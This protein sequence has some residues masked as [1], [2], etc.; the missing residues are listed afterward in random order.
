[1][2]AVGALAGLIFPRSINL[3]YY[4]GNLFLQYIISV[5]GFIANIDI[6]K[7]NLDKQTSS[8]ILGF[9]FVFVA[10]VLFLAC[11][12]KPKPLVAS[13]LAC[14]IFFTGV[15]GNAY[16]RRNET[17]IR[18]IDTGNGMCVLFMHG[19]ENILVGCGGTDFM[20]WSNISYALKNIGQLDCLIIPSSHETASSCAIGIL[21][22]NKPEDIIFDSL[23]EN[24][25]YLIGECN[26]YS[27]DETYKTKN[28]TVKFCKVNGRPYILVETENLSTL[29]YNFPISSIDELPEEFGK[30]NLAVCRLA[31]PTGISADFVAVC[32]DKDTGDFARNELVS[33]GIPSAATGGCGDLI[34]RAENGDLNIRRE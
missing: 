32:A 8:L 27:F 30:V 25:E 15:L 31:Y 29:I 4:L 26:V 7:V 5:S 33:R 24:A 28:F 34:I 18:V 10:F 17:Q 23:P 22:E 3:F 9:V 19:G 2:S 6:L 12:Y 16:F 1:M 20:A 13:A 21:K 11:F 14:V